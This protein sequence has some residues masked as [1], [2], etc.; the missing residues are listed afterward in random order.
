MGIKL[1]FYADP[2][3][4]PTAGTTY[5]ALSV[6]AGT[7][8]T[9]AQNLSG[10]LAY[11]LRSSVTHNAAS[12]LS[13]LTNA[14]FIA[15]VAA[16]AGAVATAAAFYVLARN[17]SAST[18]TAMYGLQID[19]TVNTG[20][21]S[22]TSLYGLY[23]GNQT[24][25]DTSYSIYTGLGNVSIGDDLWIR[26]D[27]DAIR[28]GTAQDATALY[29]GTD[30]ILNPRAVGTG[31]LVIAG[32]TVP[33][34]SNTW[35]L[36]SA[37]AEWKDAYLSGTIQLGTSQ[38]AVISRPAAGK[39][40]VTQ[41]A[42]TYGQTVI[43]SVRTQVETAGATETVSGAIPAGALLLGVT[44]RVTTAITGATSWD[45]GI[46]GGDLDLFGA[47]LSIDAGTTVDP[48]YYTNAAALPAF[49]QDGADLLLTANGAP[50]SGGIVVVTVHYLQLTPQSE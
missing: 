39:V 10:A 28:W 19:P 8:G 9:C 21:G 6:E 23:L 3:T 48:L 7:R 22:I 37:T 32:P 31:N 13:V 16:G 42:T 1:D 46:S 38:D 35:D 11:A 49:Y 26:T 5:R 36:G 17:L 25:G 12:A 40:A 24:A 33:S 18:V 41:G 43:A 30:F 27:N 2:A 15:T 20:G 29:D 44:A 4:T 50:F 45:L 47:A 34:A 14:Y